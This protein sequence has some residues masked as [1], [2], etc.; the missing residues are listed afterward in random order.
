VIALTVLMLLAIAFVHG[1]NR[2]GSLAAM[3]LFAAAAGACIVLLAAQDQPFA[4][5][6]RVQPDALVQV[7]P[8]A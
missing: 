1:D 6:F 3:G 4:G 5:Q 2:V 8:A 7:M